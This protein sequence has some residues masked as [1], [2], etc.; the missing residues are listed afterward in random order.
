[1]SPHGGRTHT[2]SESLRAKLCV[3]RGPLLLTPTR[4][5]RLS[6]WA[7]PGDVSPSLGVS[8]IPINEPLSDGA[9]EGQ[10]ISYG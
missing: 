2:L 9:D 3:G 10:E 8:D 1:M 5:A 7:G 4:V 6:P